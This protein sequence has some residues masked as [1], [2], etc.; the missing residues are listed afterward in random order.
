M[1]SEDPSKGYL[2]I[3]VGFHSG[4]VVANV[5]G[6]R[7]KKFCLFGDTGTPL[8]LQ[9]SP[10]DGYSD[11][12]PPLPACLALPTQS[13]QILPV[14]AACMHIVWHPSCVSSLCPTCGSYIPGRWGFLCWLRVGITHNH[15]HSCV[16]MQTGATGM[17]SQAW[18][19]TITCHAVNTAS[20]MESNSIAGRIHMSE[21]SPPPA[22]PPPAPC[23]EKG[24]ASFSRFKEG[25]Q[26]H[27][28]YLA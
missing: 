2:Q 12:P 23:K 22:P 16:L 10:L 18:L 3:R 27:R 7:N 20:R 26:L 8:F 25:L 13:S 19:T 17:R 24:L 14:A 6:T 15:G 9:L 21:V 4:P 28:G 11:A 1:D 5:V